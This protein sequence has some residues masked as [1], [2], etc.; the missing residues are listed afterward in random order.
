MK[1]FLIILL[2]ALCAFAFVSC[3]D[4]GPSVGDFKTAVNN[5]N[6]KEVVVNITSATALGELSGTYTT[7]Y[8]EDGS[9]K[10]TYAYEKFNDVSE[11]A[12][13]ELKSTVEGEITCDK[14]GNYSD[15]GELSGKVALATGAKINLDKV[16][17]A[18]I[19][20]DGNVLTVQIKAA[21]TKA[22]LGVELTTD[23]ELVITK[24]NGVITSYTLTYEN[25]SGEV[26]VTCEYK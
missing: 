18:S 3:G 8:A 14:N 25:A 15:G 5:A 26:V 21:N 6:P 10:I 1:K 24:A 9:F 17:N 4:K 13:D 16:S 12:K 7:V 20:K 11:G 22:C 2:A 23:A 19:S